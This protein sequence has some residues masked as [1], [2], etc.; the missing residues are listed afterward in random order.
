MT[1]IRDIGLVFARRAS[2][3]RRPGRWLYS[4]AGEARHARARL[5]QLV[6]LTK[7]TPTYLYGA[8]GMPSGTS[9]PLELFK[10]ADGRHW[11]YS[12]IRYKGKPIYV[13]D[14][15]IF[16]DQH[17]K[18][19]LY[20]G[21][22]W[23]FHTSSVATGS[24]FAQAYSP[25]LMHWTFS[26]YISCAAITGPSG[27]C[28]APKGYMDDNGAL[29]VTVSLGNASAPIQPYEMHPT[30]SN[31]AGAWSTPVILGMTGLPNSMIDA[32]I[33]RDGTNTRRLFYKN[34]TT[35]YIEEATSTSDFA[36]YT[37]LY[38]EN[39]GGWGTPVGAGWESPCVIKID[40][41]WYLY[42]TNANAGAGSKTVYTTTVD[43]AGTDWS[44]PAST[45][46]TPFNL[47]AL[48][49]FILPVVR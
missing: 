45:I 14:P 46:E 48:Q 5:G 40:C 13:R 3:F 25:D 26:Q 44:R 38:T 20:N 17:G 16:T 8:V 32:V 42:M 19:A 29:H 4:F 31:P 6:M 27:Y 9:G 24:S 41:T 30:T 47:Q 7:T 28:W 33:V 21:Y 43:I 23:L 1:T 10:S 15:F 22:Y 18:P 34:D 49:V 11:H 36:G 2:F 35:K 39:W 12:S 37:P